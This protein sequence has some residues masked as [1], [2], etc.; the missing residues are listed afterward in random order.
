MHELYPAGPA[1]VPA[2][3]TV[4]N[5]A[6]KRHAWI[7]MA[8][9]AVFVVLYMALAG[10]F[11]F[12]AY[13]LFAGAFGGGKNA[14]LGV[15]FGVPTAFLAVFMCKALIFLRPGG[16]MEDLEVKAA[17]Q[18]KLFEFLNRLADEAGAPRP[19]RVFLS[20][21]VNAAVF[22]DL[23]ILNFLLPSKKN[24]E[25][26]L[27]LVNALSL[28]EFKAVLAHEF[29]HFAQRSMAVGRWVYMAQQIAEHIVWRRDQLD[30]FLQGLSRSDIRIAW[31][32]WILRLIVWSI[33]SLLE[34][35]FQ[36]VMLAQRALSREM[37]FQADLVAVS[38]TGS[39]ALIHALHHAQTADDAWDRTL[40]FANGEFSNGRK[41][42][43]L[44]AVQSR[45]LERMREML[46]DPG[47]ARVPAVPDT[48]PE[49]HR[50]FRAELAQPPR[51]WLTHPHNH[52]REENAKRVY[53][54]APTDPRS[55]WELF[56]DADALRRQVSLNMVTG[57]DTAPVPIEVSLERL[58][59]C[60]AIESLQSRYVGVYLGRSVVRAEQFPRAL[61]AEGC[62]GTAA[63][64][65]QLYAPAIADEL[66]QWRSLAKE[67][68]LLER[69]EQGEFTPQ[70][71]VVHH[72]ERQLP[73]KQLPQLLTELNAELAG[74]E[75]RILAHDRA[76]RGEHLAAARRLGGGWAEYLQGLLATLHYAEHA[77]ADL[78]DAQR[79]LA[80][81]Y[82]VV[83]ADGNVSSRERKRL[84]KGCAVVHTPL[85]QIH[86]N[87]ARVHLDASMLERLGL[88]SWA[89]VFEEFK[90]ASA[91]EANLGKWL[92][93]IDGW[94]NAAASRLDRL[95]DLT[96]EQLLES[97]RKVAQSVI[98]GST[99]PPAPQPA[100][101]DAEYAYLL[102]GGERKLQR[103]LGWW[104]RFQVADGWVPAG[105]RL[106]VA[107][108]IV[109]VVI[110]YGG[111]LGNASLTV[112][113]GLATAVRVDAGGQTRTL[114]PFEAKTIEI[115]LAPLQIRTT[116]AKGH[117]IENFETPVDVA[118]A[119]YVYNVAAASPLV[120]WT[121][122][123]GGAQNVPERNLGT[124]R[125]TTVNADVLFAEPPKSISTKGEGGT[126]T[127]VIGMSD[128]GPS[129][130]QSVKTDAASLL[131]I[132]L[133]HARW[134]D[135]G[136]VHAIE[137]M[138][139]AATSPE[140]PA[141]LETRLKAQPDDVLLRRMAQDLAAEGD[142]QACT[143]DQADAVKA[144]EN[145]D[146]Q[147]L[148]ARCLPTAAE[149]NAAFR[150]GYQA[151]PQ[152]GWLAYAAGHDLA[153]TRE[154]EPAASA[155]EIARGQLRPLAN[156]ISLD[157]ERIERVLGRR[158][159][160]A[161]TQVLSA[162]SPMLAGYL[163][164]AALPSYQ[165]LQKGE[166]DAALNTEPDRRT[167]TLRLV[168]ASAGA[169]PVHIAEALALE[170]TAGLDLGTI[171]ASLGLA[172]RQRAAVDTLLSTFAESNAEEAGILRAFIEELPTGN[173][174][175]LEQ[176]LREADL[177]TRA[178]AY[179]L[180]CVAL[181]KRAPGGWKEDAERLLFA[182]ERPLL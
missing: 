147:Y 158:P 174:E 182:D 33:R 117:E 128:G 26:G 131:A 74:H 142:T 102:P 92:E 64:L 106:A 144:P 109:G 51:M 151:F 76:C 10:W 18:P 150:A 39:D 126:R 14:F 56:T 30:R 156:R 81:E 173:R 22:Y 73:R 41:I 55:A 100:R 168:A 34:T 175:R 23:T 48:R 84:V 140:F 101:I 136:S 72:R 164:Y 1:R 116:D 103:K 125:W 152:N 180:A 47:Y 28:S 7:A 29:G 143:R 70:G 16:K 38:L 11:A 37:E 65:A 171:G 68:A 161:R 95:G 120:E 4:P 119:D 176:H 167:R 15:L 113:N 63:S 25:I 145:P 99:L 97:E 165:A 78:R 43:D 129:A 122:S 19:H 50:V 13:S 108:G 153:Q 124:A 172:L 159:D 98:D 160:P 87:A 139:Y 69:V 179:V 9:L 141:I 157:L 118:F 107:S 80:R 134:D 148:A 88:E 93:V 138:S 86:A 58:D 3:L 104:D 155:L 8:A 146:L 5:Q 114:G 61:Y 24:L 53:L 178:Q 82:Q 83:T 127:V 12:K 52:E 110:G 6:Y 105:A 36:G 181:G 77:L 123:Y 60:Y 130:M 177:Q 75:Q 59:A 62:S 54:P 135:T 20:P 94:I 90:L 91:D 154:W 137:W 44:F 85:A 170:P 115:P 21:R 66:A 49:T 32:G 27:G 121:A 31:V 79:F 42:V 112:Y 149:R 71:G 163:E 2:D 67:I 46:G 35:L 169:S 57:D 133:P 166:L 162:S 45:V 89:S 132:S 96:L 40:N 111:A 17:Q